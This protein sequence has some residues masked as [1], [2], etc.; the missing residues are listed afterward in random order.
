MHAFQRITL[1]TVGGCL[2]LCISG[3]I[4]KAMHELCCYGNKRGPECEMLA[5]ACTCCMAV[6][7][8]GGDLAVMLALLD[9]YHIWSPGYIAFI[10]TCRLSFLNKVGSNVIWFV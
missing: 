6:V 2:Q 3:T 7:F 9:G 8:C 5:T 1:G 4:F 10:Q